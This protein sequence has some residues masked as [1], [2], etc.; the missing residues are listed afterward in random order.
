MLELRWNPILREWTAVATDRQDRPQMPVEGCPFCP[1]SGRVPDSYETHLYANDF[2]TLRPD[3]GPPAPPTGPP[4]L[5]RSAPSVGACEVVLYHPDH[6]AL[7]EGLPLSHIEKVVA[8]WKRRFIELAADRRLQYIYIFENRGEVIGVT[9]PHPHGQIYA[10]PFIPPRIERELESARA[11]QGKTRRCLW[12]DL[13]AEE[14]RDGRRIVAEN[15]CFTA[16]IPYFARWPY[17][18]H[19]A[20]RRHIQTIAQFNADEE[21]ALAEI[22]QRLLLQYD[23]L[24]GFPLPLMMVMHQAPVQGDFPEWHFHIEFYP[25]HRSATKLKYPAGCETGAGMF[26]N[27]TSPE[28]KARELRQ[29]SS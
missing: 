1:G 20:S 6:T 8:L 21:R 5:Y 29:A 26:I 3:A 7:L 22:L 15:D 16:G 17:E 9:M 23:K 27:D 4:E 13:L 14:R 18:V 24:F 28:E 25:P 19:L 2:P 11:H 10:F 12:C